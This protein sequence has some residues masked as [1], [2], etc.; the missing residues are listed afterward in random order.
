M[1]FALHL[2]VIQRALLV[3]NVKQFQLLTHREFILFELVAECL[4]EQPIDP[5]GDVLTTNTE[6]GDVVLKSLGL[7]V[8]LVVLACLQHLS[9]SADFRRRLIQLCLQS[10]VTDARIEVLSKTVAELLELVVFAA[11]VLANLDAAFD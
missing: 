10:S 11:V 9:A 1:N 2:V 7:E 3:L 6:H 5:V 8:R 4:H